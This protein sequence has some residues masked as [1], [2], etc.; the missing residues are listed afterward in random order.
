LSTLPLP[1]ASAANVPVTAMAFA[2]EQ[3]VV[4]AGGRASGSIY[5]IDLH[6]SPASVSLLGRQT[7]GHALALAI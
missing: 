5:I 2:T 6:Q 7:D 3:L 1:P 4:I